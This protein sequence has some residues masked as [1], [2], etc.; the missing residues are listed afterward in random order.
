MSPAGDLLFQILLFAPTGSWEVT[1]FVIRASDALQLTSQ[2]Y[3]APTRCVWASGF[4]HNLKIVSSWLT[5]H[6]SA[7]PALPR[8]PSGVFEPISPSDVFSTAHS[9]TSDSDSITQHRSSMPNRRCLATPAPWFVGNAASQEE[10]TCVLMSDAIA[11]LLTSPDA[12][13]SHT[14][15]YNAL[16]GTLVCGALMHHTA[17]TAS[18]VPIITVQSSSLVI[19]NA[20]LSL[21]SLTKTRIIGLV[22][23]YTGERVNDILK[24]LEDVSK[25]AAAVHSSNSVTSL[26]LTSSHPDSDS[27]MSVLTWAF[28]QT[29]GQLTCMG[30][31][32]TTVSHLSLDLADAIIE[33]HITSPQL[34]GRVMHLLIGMLSITKPSPHHSLHVT[35]ATTIIEKL[36]AWKPSSP[37]PLS[38][39][40]P[41]LTSAAQTPNQATEVRDL[42]TSAFQSAVSAA[43]CDITAG[44]VHTART[45]E[46][47]EVEPAEPEVLP[48]EVLMKLLTRIH[49]EQHTHWLRTHATKRSAPMSPSRTPPITIRAAPRPSPPLPCVGDKKVLAVST[50]EKSSPPA[51]PPCGSPVKRAYSPPHSL[52]TPECTG[53]MADMWLPITRS[54]ARLLT[55]IPP[56][57]RDGDLRQEYHSVVT[58]IVQLCKWPTLLSAALDVFC[59]SWPKGNR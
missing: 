3:D 21:S 17:G 18:S 15:L 50:V 43:V 51:T 48:L 5:A 6:H 57:L 26:P 27:V 41:M 11:T 25:Q 12:T 28:V 19:G 55:R 9:T 58:A 54:I 10:A 38:V 34:A 2:D 44:A 13:R 52:S 4:G 14:T 42:I 35:Y 36:L 53:M 59:K 32:S 23:G 1:A 22:T 16:L 29:P 45:S 20:L 47:M 7:L 8:R 33:A 37:S 39:R 24:S 46:L 56:T 31:A 40:D 30:S 49:N